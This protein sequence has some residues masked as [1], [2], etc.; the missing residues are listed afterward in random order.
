MNRLSGYGGQ[1][2]TSRPVPPAAALELGVAFTLFRRATLEEED[3]SED[4][5]RPLSDRYAEASRT[6]EG[7]RRGAA[8]LDIHYDHPDLPNAS[9]E[10]IY[11]F[12]RLLRE[13][14]DDSAPEWRRF[15]DSFDRFTPILHAI[16]WCPL[17]RGEAFD[18][19]LFIHMASFAPLTI[20]E[21]PTW[22]R[23]H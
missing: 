7:F 16:A 3:F 14:M 5:F 11:A 18:S 17:L 20:G 1:K 13:Q 10:R 6:E 8:I 12:V 23:I 15:Q 21:N 22:G 2:T 4:P 19:A 9:M